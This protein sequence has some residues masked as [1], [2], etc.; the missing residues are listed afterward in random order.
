V[1][2]KL[3]NDKDIVLEA[4]KKNLHALC[5]ASENMKNDKELVLEAVK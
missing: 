3:K 1:S 4:V 5:H 2:E